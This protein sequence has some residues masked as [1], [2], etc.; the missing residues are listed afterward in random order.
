MGGAGDGDNWGWLVVG[1]TGEGG[2]RYVVL[3]GGDMGGWCGQCRW[4]YV[5]VGGG[6]IR[7]PN[8]KV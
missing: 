4:W 6:W 5:M 7:W 3:G 2:M 1:A 8:C